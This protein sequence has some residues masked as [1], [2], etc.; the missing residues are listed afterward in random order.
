MDCSTPGASVH[1]IFQAKN[2]RVGCH[3]LLHQYT[4]GAD[5]YCL[6]PLIQVPSECMHLS[7]NACHYV[8][9]ESLLSWPAMQE[10]P[11]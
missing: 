5:K 4:G 8:Y 6:I 9:P 1:E 3:F 2:I 11:V 10:T 7:L